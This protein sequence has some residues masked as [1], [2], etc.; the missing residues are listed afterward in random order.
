MKCQICGKETD[1]SFGIYCGRC[2]KIAADV[3][4]DLAADIK[5]GII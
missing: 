5:A 4:M 1:E 3:M 2:D